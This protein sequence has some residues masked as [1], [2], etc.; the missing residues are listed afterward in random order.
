M[1]EMSDSSLADLSALPFEL[2][3]LAQTVNYQKWVMSSIEPFLGKRILELGSGIGNMSQHFSNAELIYLTEGDPQCYQFLA[4][5]IEK[6]KKEGL[7][8]QGELLDLNTPWVE[9]LSQMNFDTV[10]SFNVMEHIE[11]DEAAFRQQYHILKNSTAPGPKRIVVFAPAHPEIYGTLDRK[12][13]HFRR[14]DRERIRKIFQT[15]DPACKVTSRYF[16]V[17]GVIGWILLGQILKRNEIGVASAQTFEKIIPLVRGFDD[18]IHKK[19]KLPIG[20][21]LISVITI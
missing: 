17:V 16:N 9:R 1:G 2:Q 7:A 3:T 13:L 20:Q 4:P 15:I 21:S 14:Y 6:K 11:D 10:I 8:F 5:F 19:L 18:F 12:F